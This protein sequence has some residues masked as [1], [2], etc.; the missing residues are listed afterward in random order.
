MKYPNV[1]ILAAVGLAL[2]LVPLIMVAL[3][4]WQPEKLSENPIAL[5]G[6]VVEGNAC[7]LVAVIVWARR[8]KR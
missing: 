3:A 1:W 4:L 6:M 8:N 2:T 7:L 5:M